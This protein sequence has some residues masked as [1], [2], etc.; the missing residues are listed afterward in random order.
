M[1]RIMFY[2]APGHGHLYPLVPTMTE[3]LS[4]RHEVVV[5]A[6]EGH[7]PA[8]RQRG[9]Q[10]AAIDARIEQ[11]EDDTWRARTPVGALRRSVRMYVD[12][13]RIEVDDIRQAI[14]AE[15]PDLVVVDNNCW[16]AAAV[17][18]AGA[19]PWAQ[20]ATFLLPLVTP[21]APPFGL[22]L[23][24]SN[25]WSA[26]L[27]DALIRRSAMPLF[28]GLLPPINEL[29]RELDVPPVEH[30]PDLYMRAPLVLSYTAQPLEYP[31][32]ELPSS[33]RMVGPS[34][35]D[36]ADEQERPDWLARRGRPIVLVT[37]SSQFQNDAKLIQTALDALDGAPY[38]V[39]VT[40]ASLD[41]DQFRW[42]AN[43]RVERFVPHSLLLERAVC[44]V[45]HGGMG[46]TQ[47]ALLAGVPV[48]VVPFGRDQLEVGQRVQVAGAGVRLPAMLL[49]T[50]R[51]RRAIQRTIELRDGARRVSR[52]LRAAGGADAAADALED[53]LGRKATVTADCQ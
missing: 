45:C 27:R 11:R 18:E 21:D 39:I 25:R 37:C 30:V 41:P 2:T 20:V 47:K 24:P 48:C 23:R 8:L 13:A 7:V 26:R 43:A 40:T 10:A 33:V 22:G 50:R 5:R 32:T 1:S 53:L 52:N 29:R 14:D 9:M 17:L 38:E 3:L 49:S 31:R 35:W 6:E 19:M 34:S 44:V 46:I 51:L 4:R 28:D 36:P 16:G 12:R 42:P 15:R